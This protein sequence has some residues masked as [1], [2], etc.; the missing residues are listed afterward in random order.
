M[1]FG[2]M[3]TTGGAGAGLTVT[4]NA[5]LVGL[6]QTTA[7]LAEPPVMVQIAE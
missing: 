3:L 6:A 1:T 5:E 4:L 7:E 2:T